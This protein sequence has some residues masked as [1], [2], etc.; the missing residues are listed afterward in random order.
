VAKQTAADGHFV[1]HAVGRPNE[2]RSKPTYTDSAKGPNIVT[3]PFATKETAMGKYDRI[4]SPIVIKG[5]EFKNRIEVA[6]QATMLATP[7]GLVT[8]DLEDYYRT[9][10]QGGFGIVTV[11]ETPIDADYARGHYFAL[12]LGSD[13]VITGLS[14]LV[15]S[16]ARYGAQP[17]IELSHAGRNA[18]PR[19]LDGKKPVGPSPIPNATEEAAA[20]RQGR[21]PAEVKQ[22]NEEQID[23]IIQ[24]F[25]DAVFRCQVAGFNIVMLHG[26]HGHLLAQFLS[27]YSNQ[28]SDRWGGT[29]EK[30][31]R[32]P[33]AVLDAVRKKCGPNLIIEYRISLDEKLPGGMKPEETLEF[34]KMV[35][36]KIDI[37]H[38]SAGSLANPETIQHMIQ[39]FYTRHMYNVHLAE[40]VKKHIDIPVT[41]VG[42][43]MT[44]EN[45]ETILANGWADFVAFARPVLADPE[46]L[47]KTAT[48][49][50][51]DVR[52]CLRCNSCTRRTGLMRN[53]RCAVNPMAG[54]GAEF[55]QHEGLAPAR[56]KRKVMV[57]GGGPAGMQA[58]QTAVQR[59]HDVVLYEMTDRLGGMLEASSKLPFKKDLEKYYHWMVA[60]TEKCGAKI[61]LNTGVT[62]DT[63]RSEKPDVLI[64][65]VGATPFIPNIPGIESKKVFWAGDVDSGKAQTGQSVIVIG[66]GLTGVETAINLGSQG[67]TVSIIEM[68]GPDIVIAEAAS[69]HKFYLLD[70][71]KEYNIRIVT[72]TKVEA[73]TDK[74]V[75]TINKDFQW[76]D[77]EAD[78][79]V[80]A[81]GMSPRKEKVAELHRLIPETEVFVVGDC[82][83]P[84]NIFSANHE[85]F[86]A[87]CDL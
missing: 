79:V 56:R 69:A 28:R 22:M 75:R 21:I 48:G 81:M 32:F 6:P 45:A 63:V 60:Q 30:R 12:N 57:V 47:R 64:I 23:E 29:P 68:M 53:H 86:N 85:A 76:A 31:A 42:S 66:A 87:L 7:Q 80:L 54:R 5:V 18:K 34:L 40:L 61:V 55:N 27:P 71:I 19:L 78:T 77:Y 24:H 52:P 9:Y 10:A 8:S 49:R 44:L 72:H 84:R 70:R 20:A 73:I 50:E 43:I 4:F 15:E 2:E 26:G 33:M 82:Y 1:K 46:M 39:P 14:E 58:A 67:K 62:A 59:G 38:V 16:I 3:E 74:G 13:D 25:A 36:N 35:K 51:E 17:S 41:A 37:V 83:K 65:A 11:G